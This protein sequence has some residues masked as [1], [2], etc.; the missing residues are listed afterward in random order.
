M[1]KKYDFTGWVTKNDLLCSD[2]RTIRKDAFKDCDGIE[3]PLVYHHDHSDP[4]NVL[5][6]ILL[7]NRD[8]GV[9]GYGEFN[10][11]EKAQHVKE[12]VRH[13]DIKYL[14]I[15][16]NRLKQNAGD[17][18][19]GMIREVSLVMTGANPGATIET[20]LG[21]AE[22]YDE[23]AIITTGEELMFE[24][25]N[26]LSHA[27]EKPAE[28]P[29]V[30]EPANDDAD[31]TIDDIKKEIDALNPRQKKAVMTLVG[32]AASKG[33]TEEEAKHSE[34]N[35]EGENDDMKYNAFENKGA[36]P[37]KNYISH[38]DFKTIMADAKRCGSLKEAVLAHMEDEDGV[39]AHIDTTG[40]T[41]SEGNQQYF[42]NQPSFL[43]P[44][45]K[46]LNNPP[47]WIKRETGWVQKV[48][49]KV[50][51]T[52]FSRIKSVFADITEDEA[53]AKGYI[54]GNLKTEE[55]FTLLK[56]TT[57]PQ[58]I[59]KK[60][61]WDRDDILDIT[62]FDTIAW[63]RAEMRMMLDEEIARAILIGDGRSTASNDHIS[64][65]HI[66]PVATDKPLFTVKVPVVVPANATP[67]DKAAALMDAAISSRKYY[68]GSGSP[69]FFTTEDVIS[70][71]LL[72]KDGVGHRFYKTEGEVA[73]A[74]RVNSVIPVEVMENYTI[75]DDEVLGIAVNLV[76]YNVGADKGGQVN[77]FDDFDLDYN[78][79]KY[80]IE[81]RCSGALIKPYSALVFVVEEES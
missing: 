30:K 18:L 41:V 5:G 44:E 29:K 45:P 14:S 11:T 19:H 66:R 17:V 79:Q 71:C 64:E 1:G 39:L 13:G 23:E 8:D 12:A 81:T 2:G 37:A 33:N 25:Q 26:E 58:T 80:L 7:E 16:A 9:Y 21:H 57:D 46:A 77:M 70:S 6:K 28:E 51:H 32:Y 59:Y 63:I 3:V 69:D 56:R 75:D 78:Q 68:K 53:R 27:E 31:M 62:D 60:Q 40:M 36:A 54:K 65:D 55:V 61:K 35:D 10:S 48:L 34:E 76:D 38:E 20:V 50:H 74:M 22:E 42:V 43:F 15:Y 52:P 67:A 73:T 49:G 24:N 4:T 72:L 47:E